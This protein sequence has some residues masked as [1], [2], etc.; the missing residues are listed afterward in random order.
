MRSRLLERRDGLNDWARFMLIQSKKGNSYL[1]FDDVKHSY[2]LNGQHVPGVTTFIH[3]GYVTSPALIGWMKGQT[4]NA[5][6]DA[7]MKKDSDGYRPK[8]NMPWPLGENG[9]KEIIKE[10][11]TADKKKSEEAASIGTLTHDVAFYTE[12][13]NQERLIETMELIA[14]HADKEKILGCVGQFRDWKKDNDDVMVASE[15]IVGSVILQ[16]AGKFDRLVQRKGKLII[17]D[18]KTSGAMYLEQMIQMAAY[19]I[20]IE[21][22][23]ELKIEGMEVLRF[24]KDDATFQTLLVDK[25]EEIEA[26][27]KQA[28]RCRETY[29]FTKLGSDRRWA[30]GGKGKK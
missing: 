25:P 6:F 20:M 10:A 11:K 3:S 27:K 4:G 23:L 18:F 2:T 5:V 14:K 19:G 16:A 22:W 12:T 7:L 30:W 21:E 29:E 9:R 1:T 13:N 28:I 26:F 24:G 15:E 8:T 17:S